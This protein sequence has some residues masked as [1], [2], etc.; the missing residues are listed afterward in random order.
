MRLTNVFLPLILCLLGMQS[1]YAQQTISGYYVDAE[2]N[3]REAAFRFVFD[4]EDYRDFLMVGEGADRV[5]TPDLVKEVGFENGRV[6]RS[7]MLPDNEE[8]AFVL[9]MRDG[10]VDLLKWQKEYFL[11]TEGQIVALREL[12][13][14]KDV[15]GQETK[16]T[17]KQ[18]QGVLISVLKPSPEQEKLGKE[19]RAS[20]LNDRD[21]TRV[22]DLYHEVNGLALDQEVTENQ[23]PAFV[24][25]LKVQAGLGVQGLMKN[26]ENQGFNYQ[27][28][29]GMA[30]YIE[31]G[32]RFRDFRSAPRL[33]VDLGLA[34]YS[35][36]DV[37]Q[38]EASR[39]SFDLTGR[40]MFK[41]SSVVVPLELH[42]IFSKGKSS[43][44]Y[45][46]TGISF[47]FSS[48]ENELAEV[49]LDNGEPS[50]V[51]NT[52][53]FV[54]RKSASVSPNLKLGW[55]RDISSKSQI[56]VEAKGDLLLKNYEMHPFA[57]YAI[58]NL[59]VL[60]ISA[61]ITF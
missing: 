43:E 53:D 55:S 54:S 59:G 24:T 34:Y 52:D 28:E 60:T 48:Y 1:I 16:I 18:Y 37:V 49:F 58:Y 17:T 47:W 50:L 42:Y 30:P 12:T 11:G 45:A 27:M 31:A 22:I 57:Y 35:E 5:L 41:S 8:K 56:F 19:I 9:V 29:S 36:S 15:N 38:A 20:G 46:G 23:G 3:H 33:F 2:G 13:S 7:L 44:W 25:Q 14:N 61:G 51:T 26:F 40:Q 21:L 4:Q 10:E 32:V 6:F 39:I